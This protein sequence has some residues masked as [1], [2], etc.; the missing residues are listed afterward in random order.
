M[1]LDP[2]IYTAFSTITNHLF[3]CSNPCNHC[4]ILRDQIYRYLRCGHSKCH[5]LFSNIKQLI[6]Y[7]FLFYSSHL[8]KTFI[9]GTLKSNLFL[10]IMSSRYDTWLD[11]S[12]TFSDS[13]AYIFTQQKPDKR[14]KCRGFRRGRRNRFSIWS[15]PGAAWD[16]NETTMRRG[17][18]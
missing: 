8:H 2:R 14:I 5:L 15:W 17:W 11:L 12:L 4:V 9:L 6:I 16:R 18:R 7:S 1:K 3:W 13:N 10:T